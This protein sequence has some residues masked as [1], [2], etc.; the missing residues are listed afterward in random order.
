MPSAGKQES[1]VKRETT[2]NRRQARE[3]KN[4][5]LS[6]GKQESAVNAGQQA[7]SAPSA[8]KQ[9]HYVK[10]GGQAIGA[11]CGR[12]GS[13][14]HTRENKQPAPTAGKQQSGAEHSKTGAQHGKKLD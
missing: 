13:R 10:R 7:T 6:A 5:V 1:H 4:S 9:E 12:T 3:N 2:G 11:K 14:Q 8:G